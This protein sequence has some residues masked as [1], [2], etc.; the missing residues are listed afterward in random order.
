M[1]DNNPL[2]DTRIYEVE[3]QDRNN[4]SLVSNTI[5]ISILA[6]VDKEGNIYVLFD[7][8]VDHRTV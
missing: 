4:A 1:K 7:H 2:L 5:V 6:Q 3:Y 8:T